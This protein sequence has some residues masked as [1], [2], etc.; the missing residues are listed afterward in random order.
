M[1]VE[2]II[3]TIIGLLVTMG[4][5]EFIKKSNGLYGFSATLLSVGVSFV[6]ALVAVAIEM[7]GSG[8]FSAE[9]LAQYGLSIFTIATIAYRGI[10][11]IMTD[12]A[13][14]SR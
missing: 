13:A 2:Y 10:Q 6:V 7:F 1:D 12:E 3:T 4:V 8:E 9:N 14:A 11:K 5:T